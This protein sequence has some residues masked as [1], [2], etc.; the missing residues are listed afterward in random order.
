MGLK[1]VLKR[2]CLAAV[3]ILAQS[4]ICR[5]ISFITGTYTWCSLEKLIGGVGRERITWDV[6]CSIESFQV[7][8]VMADYEEG[9]KD[10]A[11]DTIRQPPLSAFSGD[12]WSLP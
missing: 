3:L 5:D 4:D 1:K 2:L 10:L 7:L 11:E 9:R 8:L 12:P 6:R